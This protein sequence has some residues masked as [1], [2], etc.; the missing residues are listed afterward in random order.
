MA[1]LEATLADKFV[2]KL[3]YLTLNSL[4]P[5]STLARGSGIYTGSL[6]GDITDACVYLAFSESVRDTSKRNLSILGCYMIVV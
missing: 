5:G 2:G 1:G 6:S 4:N 3:S